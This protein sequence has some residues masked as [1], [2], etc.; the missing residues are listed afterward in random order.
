MRG[1]RLGSHS[2]EQQPGSG[3]GRDDPVTLD[4]SQ[5]G[6]CAAAM[7]NTVERDGSHASGSAARG[8]AAAAIELIVLDAVTNCCV[9]AMQGMSLDAAKVSIE[10]CFTYGQMGL[11][12]H[13]VILRG[14][15][16]PT[17]WHRH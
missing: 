17:K 3:A 15:T 16:T 11:A 13:A 1:M 4:F 8:N 5:D 10:G 12:T 7:D 14:L 6:S 9:S 2:S